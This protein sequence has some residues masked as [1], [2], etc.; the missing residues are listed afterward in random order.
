ML[1]HALRLM[2]PEQQALEVAERLRIGEGLVKTI[3]IHAF[4]DEHTFEVD[5][6]KKCCTHYALPDGRLMPGCA[7]NMFYR[8]KDPWLCPQAA[9]PTAAHLGSKRQPGSAT[10]QPA[11]SPPHGDG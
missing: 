4:M 9:G 2:Y 10:L 3:F 6:I 7:Y 8:H 11:D 5:R 1:K